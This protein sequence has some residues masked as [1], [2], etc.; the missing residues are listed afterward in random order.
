MQKQFRQIMLDEFQDINGQQAELIFL[1]RSENVFFG[2]GD[3]NQSIYGFRHAR[4]EIFTGYQAE[5]AERELQ[6]AELLHNFRSREAILRCIRAVMA[7]KDG[8]ADRELVAGATFAAKE[9]PSIEV[10]KVGDS[11]DDK[12]AACDREA[13]WI[14]HRVH[15][16]CGSLRLGPP[17]ETRVA[18]FRDVAVLCRSGDSMQPILTAF[19]R[20]GIPYVCGR[21]VSFLLSREG[22]DITALLQVI[23]NCVTAFRSQ[24]CFA[25]RWWG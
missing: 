5:V 20:A 24:R 7:E 13:A 25:R 21:R 4:P 16:L 12:D 15:A 11:G 19:D 17:G 23:V 8:I 1:L 14:A 18:E 6:A 22:L 3:G 2:V 10:L 9:E